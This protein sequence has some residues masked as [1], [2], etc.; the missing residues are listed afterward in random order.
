MTTSSESA[1]LGSG[2][3]AISADFGRKRQVCHD[4]YDSWGL[5]VCYAVVFIEFLVGTILAIT[6]ENMVILYGFII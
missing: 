4:E 2:V 6:I 1:L 3:F 5:I